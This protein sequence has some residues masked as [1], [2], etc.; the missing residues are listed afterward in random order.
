MRRVQRFAPLWLLALGLVSTAWAQQAPVSSELQVQ[1][2]ETVDGATVFKPAQV[3]KPGDVL[4]YR[5]SYTNHSNAAVTGLVANLPIP[6]GTTLV[7]KSQL[8]PDALASTDGTRFAPLPLMRRVKQADGRENELPV[9]LEEYRALRWTLGTLA[10]GKSEQ[11]SARVRVNTTLPHLAA[12]STKS[13][14]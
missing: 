13:T 10:P 7:D 9:P 12:A 3:S 5:V 6:A 14:G 11:V 2:V 4:E 1:R 8:P